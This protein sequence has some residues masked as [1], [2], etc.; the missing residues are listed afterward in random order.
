MINDYP[1][2]WENV[3]TGLAKESK[4]LELDYYKNSILV[5]VGP[6]DVDVNFVLTFIRNEYGGIACIHL[7]II[8]IG[9][10]DIKRSIDLFWTQA[11]SIL[12]DW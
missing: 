5:L 6:T 8:E 3:V 1:A 9:R 4:F 7:N 12:K 11:V 2:D 10:E